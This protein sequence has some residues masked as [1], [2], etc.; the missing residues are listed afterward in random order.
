MRSLPS[1]HAGADA[2]GSTTLGGDG[3][4]EGS[5]LGEGDASL[6]VSSELDDN[7]SQAKSSSRDA[8]STKSAWMRQ[9]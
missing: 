5:G 3:D 6:R 8:A 7:G 9:E 4:T 2:G 1:S